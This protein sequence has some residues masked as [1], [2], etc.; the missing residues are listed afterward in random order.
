MAGTRQPAPASEV[1]ALLFDCDECLVRYIN[2]LGIARSNMALMLPLFGLSLARNLGRPHDIWL[3]CGWNRLKR[4][5]DAA[6]QDPR[7]QQCW[8]RSKFRRAAAPRQDFG[9]DVI[10]PLTRIA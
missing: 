5:A 1:L 2:V 10:Y 6:M 4:P 3:T 7:L 8:V 9:C